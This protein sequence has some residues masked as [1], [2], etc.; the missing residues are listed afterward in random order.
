MASLLGLSA[1]DLAASPMWV[2]TGADQLL[3]PLKTPMPYVAR[4][5]TAAG[6][7][8]GRK[9]AWDARPPMCSPSIPTGQGWFAISSPSRAAAWPRMGTGSACANLGGWLLA[10]GHALPA[11]YEVDQGEQ[12]DRR[13]RLDLSV[14]ADGAIRVGGRV[15]EL[16]RGTVTI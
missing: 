15:I 14:T 8:S 11:Q 7:S 13:C 10:T 1:D 4:N 2:D 9:A 12:V 5:R 6:W 3:V 16:G